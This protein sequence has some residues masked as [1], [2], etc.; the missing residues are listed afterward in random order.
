MHVTVVRIGEKGANGVGRRGVRY[1]VRVSR[2]WTSLPRRKRN[3]GS[4][5]GGAVVHEV[6]CGGTG[7][8]EEVIVRHERAGISGLIA[9]G[10]AVRCSSHGAIVEGDVITEG[11]CIRR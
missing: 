2:R 5:G 4:A 6:R 8:D 7:A 10:E 1:G 11:A 9:H 3:S